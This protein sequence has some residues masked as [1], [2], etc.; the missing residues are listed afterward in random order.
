MRFHNHRKV[1]VS[2][3]K[4]EIPSRARLTLVISRDFF[5]NYLKNQPGGRFYLNKRILDYV[6]FENEEDAVMFILKNCVDL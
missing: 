4:C 3:I 2:W 6:Y 5:T 1:V